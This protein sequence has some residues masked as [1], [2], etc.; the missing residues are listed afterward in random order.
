MRQRQLRTICPHCDQVFPL[1]AT[2][3]PDDGP[4]ESGDVAL[5]ME[6]ERWAIY[7]Y[8]LPGLLRA[9]T[10]EELREIA[11]LTI[12]P[13]AAALVAEAKARGRRSP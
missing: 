11:K 4:P 13:A 3:A 1:V 5:C 8:G 7:D 9:A 10:E 2:V 6:C 12:A